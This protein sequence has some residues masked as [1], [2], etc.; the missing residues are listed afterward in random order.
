[1]VEVE[2]GRA[3]RC[4]EEFLGY[5]LSHREEFLA[6]VA[7]GD[8]VLKITTAS[9][10]HFIVD[11]CMPNGWWRKSSFFMRFYR[12]LIN[13]LTELGYTVTFEGG[14][15]TRRIVARPIAEAQGIASLWA[16]KPRQKA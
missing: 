3:V 6:N 14:G 9:I 4:A 10:E 2:V 5:V 7:R 15:A 13:R 8:G 1:M 11:R 16:V 12:H